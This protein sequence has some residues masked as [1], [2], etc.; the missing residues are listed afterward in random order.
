[1][2]SPMK[3][4]RESSN[5]ESPER[6]LLRVEDA[7]R[8]ILWIKEC[9]IDGRDEHGVF[10][11]WP[12]SERDA[13][14]RIAKEALLAQPEGQNNAAGQAGRAEEGSLNIKGV[15][16][17]ERLPVPAAPGEKD[18]EGLV[19]RLRKK[20]SPT[21]NQPLLDGIVMLINK[22]G[23]EAA[24][25]IEQ[26]ERELAEANE[27]R[28]MWHQ[29]WSEHEAALSLRSA[30]GGAQEGLHLW[31]PAEICRGDE[32]CLANMPR[33]RY[34]YVARGSE[35]FRF[36][37]PELPPPDPTVGTGTKS[38]DRMLPNKGAK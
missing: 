5:S 14:Y 6:R 2:Q 35:M 28:V 12:E 17:G 24:D 32:L 21:P 22:M 23:D 19:A 16:K 38:I 10:R 31:V 8:H 37:L 1:M 13:M 26:L 15:G 18:G 25:R 30:R 34:V 27:Q 11:N 36:T 3:P 33:D 29:R 9:G 7:L 20:C 4:S